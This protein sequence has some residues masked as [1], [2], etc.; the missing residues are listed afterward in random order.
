MT[1]TDKHCCSSMFVINEP[2]FSCWLFPGFSVFLVTQ[3]N[4][5]FQ[6][7]FPIG[8]LP[9]FTTT[10]IRAIIMSTK[11]IFLIQIQEMSGSRHADSL[12]TPGRRT[13]TQVRQ[14]PEVDRPQQVQPVPPGHREQSCLAPHQSAQVMKLF[15]NPIFCLRGCCSTLLPEDP[16]S[17]K[18]Q[19]VSRTEKCE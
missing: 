4:I 15:W 14:V 12:G 10:I 17:V 9:I 2:K 16:N 3:K 13:P 8:L 18:T 11:T 7:N 1:I 6:W 5:S 19:N